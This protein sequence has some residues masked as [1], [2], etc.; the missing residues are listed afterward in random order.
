[1]TTDYE[2]IRQKNIEEYGK[3][4]RHLSY[5]S[6]IYST[7]THFIYEVLQNAEDALSR[8][9][10][11]SSPGYVYFNLYPDRLVIRHNGE[12]FSEKDVIGICGIGEGTKV[13]DYTQIGKFGIGFKSVYAYTFF[14]QIHSGDEHFK[15]Q[16][17]VEPHIIDNVGSE[18]TLIVLPFDKPQCRPEWAFREDVAAEKAV[19]E[20]GN[21]LQELGIRTL[22][23]LRHIEEIKWTLPNGK[24]GHF[25]RSSSPIENY[26]G[27][28]KVEVLDQD[29][30]LEDWRI[31][32]R[33]VTVEDTGKSHT[34]P[35]E[36]AFLVKDGFVT[37]AQNT[38]L[39]IFFPTEKD[40]KLGFL[41][42]APFKATKARDNIKADDTA[43]R[44]MIQTAAELAAD[45]LAILRDMGLLNVASF[46]ALPIRLMDFQDSPLK[47]VYEMVRKALKTEPLLPAHGGGFIKADEAKLAR[48]KDLVELFSPE[49][50]AVLFG[51]AKLN[52]L[53]ASITESGETTDLHLYLVGRKKQYLYDNATA[54]E[55]LLE[56]IQVEADTLAPKLTE[57][58]LGKQS[59]K[60]LVRFTLYAIQGAQAIKKAPFIRL[61]SG[62]H[63]SLPE[64]KSVSPPAWFTPDNKSDLDLAMFPLVHDELIAD[65]T[66]RLFLEEKGIR[67][68]DAA[69]I[70]E[71]SILPAFQKKI[72][73]ENFDEEIYRSHLR[74]IVNAYNESDKSAKIQ[75]NNCLNSASWL[76]CIR[77]SGK[78]EEIIWKKPVSDSLSDSLFAR[79]PNHETWFAGLESVEAYFLH[80]LIENSLLEQLIPLAKPID[81]LTKNLEASDSGTITLSNSHSS[82]K[83]GLHGF[84][85]DAKIIGLKDALT[86]WNKSRFK[87][88]WNILLNAPRII[89][90][91]TQFASN[92]QKLDAAPKKLEYTEVGNLCRDHSWLPD[93][94]DVWHE[95]SKLFLTDL[96]EEFDTSS[97]SAREVAEK[98]G[99][100]KPEVE[101]AINILAGNDPNKLSQLERFLSA[102]EA[103]REKM[104]KILPEESAPV[105]APSFKDRL[106]SL[107]RP[108]RGSI[109]S[110][111]TDDPID[112]IKKPELYQNIRDQ[113]VEGNVKLHKTTSQTTRYLPVRESLSNKYARDFLYEQY[114]GKCQITGNTFTKASTNTNGEA[115][116]YFE[117]CSLL[118]YN[119]ADYLNDA[120]NMLCVSADVMAKLKHASFTGLD[121]SNLGPIIEIFKIRKPGELENIKLKIQLA[122]EEC[123]ITWSERHFARLV[124]LWD[125]A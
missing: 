1:M 13:G 28:R 91:E 73:A 80:P 46:N 33:D 67:K 57:A 79:T 111:N 41:I 117:A 61:K 7:R 45:S 22:L 53:D 122:G 121:K 123:E 19:S 96:P 64:N 35:V 116:N 24:S 62:E 113:E 16:R 120:G 75:L 29:V 71:K 30:D 106:N 36:V 18:Y 114:Q 48:G 43:N 94:N 103:N 63:V 17:F 119:N 56:G 93:Q 88:L 32:S 11:D 2:R 49:Q 118:S 70:V 40:T 21:A 55:P 74:H 85:P 83:R 81:V 4:T 50:L 110:S 109:S 77:A 76:A 6:D 100:K 60:W 66:I 51:K 25:I 23:F 31:F 52:W 68:I 72:N 27:I 125:K 78:S 65:E 102:S 47:C 20:I 38:Q 87:I 3:G 107:N 12:P 115:E 10:A 44:Q 90:G 92:Y 59:M 39:V 9:S 105:P 89:S 8:R 42:Q 95:P 86:Q 14:P 82:N 34:V 104:L 108:Q 101:Q 97:I 98:L 112:L 26:N 84:R 54:V 37:K 5:F 99:M 69:A 15:I 124:A 58:F